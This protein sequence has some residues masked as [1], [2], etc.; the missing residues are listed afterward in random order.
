MRAMRKL[1][2]VPICRRRRRFARTHGLQSA[3]YCALGVKLSVTE[4]REPSCRDRASHITLAVDR[5]VHPNDMSARGENP[6]MMRQTCR[7]TD[8]HL[9][10][11]S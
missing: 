1:S 6:D 5:A 9:E 4:I 7:L 11:T 3:R 2:V 10:C 8:V